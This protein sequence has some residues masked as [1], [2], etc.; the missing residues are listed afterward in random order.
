MTGVQTCALPIPLGNKDNLS[1]RAANR[2]FPRARHFCQKKESTEAHG[3]SSFMNSSH[4]T[5][6][7][8]DKTDHTG[9][10][11]SAPARR[12]TPTTAHPTFGGKLAEKVRATLM[13]RPI[14]SDAVCLGR[15]GQKSRPNAST[16]TDAFVRLPTHSRPIFGSNLRRR[17]HKTDA[18]AR[19][20]SSSGP[21]VSGTLASQH[22][23]A[24]PRPPASSSKP[25]AIF[26]DRKRI[27]R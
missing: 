16:Q 5:S 23:T 4:L 13:G 3:S 26:S 2:V 22:P 1:Q 8:E 21:L 20:L 10:W 18:R 15:C 27:H 6:Y 24:H 7:R 17:G 11:S 25:P 9:C 14:S 12:A 19:P